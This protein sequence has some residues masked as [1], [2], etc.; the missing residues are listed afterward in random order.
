MLVDYGSP[1]DTSILGIDLLGFKPVSAK[2]CKTV[3]FNDI[4]HF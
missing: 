3:G 1:K 4:Y 2:R